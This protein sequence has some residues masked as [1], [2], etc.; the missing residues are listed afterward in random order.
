MTAANNLL[1]VPAP[2]LPASRYSAKRTRHHVDFFCDAPRASAVFL[3]GD[4]NDWQP[5]TTPMQRTPDGR[6]TV[7]LELHHGHHLYLF[8]VDGKPML[9]PSARGVTRNH[10]NEAVSL[11]AVS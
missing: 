2:A 8:L 5:G 7:S 6:W 4:F 9:D 11:T 3:T 10:R 1:S